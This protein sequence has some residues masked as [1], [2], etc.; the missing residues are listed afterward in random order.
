MMPIIRSFRSGGANSTS[1]KLDESYYRRGMGSGF[2]VNEPY[3]ENASWVKLRE[4]N[5]SYRVPSKYMKKFKLQG[6]P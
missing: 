3:M 1:V 2:N 4:V 6:L 5:L